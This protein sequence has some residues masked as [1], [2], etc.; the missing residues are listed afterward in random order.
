MAAPE[1]VPQP[2][3]RHV[4]SYSSPPW[5][6]ESWRPER[7]GDLRGPQPRG[8]RL[9]SPGPDQGYIYLL[10][11]RF[12][13]RL[14]LAPGEH[15]DDAIAGCVAVALKRASLLGRA[16]VAVDLSAAFTI[17]GFLNEAPDELIELRRSLFA[18]VA[19]P[20]HYAAQRHIADLVPDDVLRRTP[21]QIAEAHRTSWRSLLAL[22]SDPGDA[23]T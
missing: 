13:G 1:Y 15:E 12:Q 18:E 17:W 3:I 22:E 11:R 10:A 21:Q 8:E 5:R 6:A 23:D 19:N 9:G 2:A 4:R 7:P 14:R 20:H 16:P